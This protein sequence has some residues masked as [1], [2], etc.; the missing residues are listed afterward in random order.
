MPNGTGK[1]VQTLSPNSFQPHRSKTSGMD[2]VTVG[3]AGTCDFGPSVFEFCLACSPYLAFCTRF[4]FP[5]VFR[6]VPL[7]ICFVICLARWPLSWICFFYVFLFVCSAS[8][9]MFMMPWKFMT[10]LFLHAFVHSCRVSCFM[11]VYSSDCAWSS[12]LPSLVMRWIGLA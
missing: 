7:I 3:I 12:F 11:S 4:I 8:L 10:F 6:A 2:S 9:L 5:S 1:N